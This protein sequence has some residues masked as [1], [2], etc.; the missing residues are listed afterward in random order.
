[1]YRDKNISMTKLT[2]FF[3]IIF[4]IN[5]HGYAPERIEVKTKIIRPLNW[6]HEQ[7]NLWKE[8]SVQ[9]ADEQAWLNY[10][11]AARYALWSPSDLLKIQ[12]AANET[13]NNSPV[14][15]IITAWHNS[16]SPAAASMLESAQLATQYA[17]IDVLLSMQYELNLNAIGRRTAV[18][19]LWKNGNISESLM[20]RL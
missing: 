15:K 8:A 14:N 20:N 11:T 10:Y 4:L 18:E 13:L 6:Y 3:S 17:I 1:M 19:R 5:V 12:I 16:T 7:A 2:F 9:S